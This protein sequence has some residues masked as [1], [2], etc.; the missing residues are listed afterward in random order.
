MPQGG[1]KDAYPPKPLRSKPLNYSTNFKGDRIEIQFNEFFD[2]D[3]P[4]SNVVVS[5]P[6]KEQ[7]L[8]RKRGKK[9][10]IDFQEPLRPNTTYN[11]FFGNTI[12]DI[13]EGNVLNNYQ[14]VFSTGAVL[15]SLGMSGEIIDAYSKEPVE[16]AYVMLYTD[17]NDTVTLDSLPYKVDPQYISRTGADGVFSLNNLAD[18]EYKI[19]ALKTEGIGYTYSNPADQIAF[20]DTLLRPDVIFRKTLDTI[21]ADSLQKDSIVMAYQRELDSLS[22]AGVM[23]TFYHM[24][25]FVEEDTVQKLDK[26]EIAGKGKVLFVFNEPADDITIEAINFP[27]LNDYIIPEFSKNQDSITWYTKDFPVDTL[28]LLIQSPVMET[29]TLEFSLITKEERTKRAL[30]SRRKKKKEEEEKVEL[31]LIKFKNN[32][33]GGKIDLDK[34]LK[35]TFDYPIVNYDFS[36]ALMVI[37]E[38]TTKADMVFT[39]KIQRHLWV[40]HKVEP[41]MKYELIIPDSVMT[42]FRGSQN[43]SIRLSYMSR[44]PEDYGVLVMDIVLP[45]EGVNYILQLTDEKYNP[46]QEMPIDSSQIIEY[47]YLLPG[48]Y[49][50]RLIEDK[51]D[52]GMWLTGS[53]SMKRQPAKIFYFD[54]SLQLRANWDIQESWKVTSGH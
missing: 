22:A 28:N 53:Y 29:D 1:P 14:F 35:L 10:L 12:K 37:G 33:S 51:S 41:E 39:D 52:S 4:S 54:K 11:I 24:Y 45:Q 13:T 34:Q 21:F 25:M 27:E 30:E 26:A 17:N 15:D 20:L 5:P 48:K 19:F 7:P 46:I 31:P 36:N 43:D 32:L 40:K 38:D 49:S 16:G 50:F 2:L 42:D 3:D 47:D 18:N 8:F 23:N 44:I 6:V 9:L